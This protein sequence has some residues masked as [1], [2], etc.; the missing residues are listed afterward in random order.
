MPKSQFDEEALNN[1]NMQLTHNLL[2]EEIFRNCPETVK[3]T[4]EDALIDVGNVFSTD[5]HGNINSIL[6]KG[7][8][9]FIF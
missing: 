1:A 8:G 5:K 3:A 7:I 4:W 2:F 6:Q 9:F